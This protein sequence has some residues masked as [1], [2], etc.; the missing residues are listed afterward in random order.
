MDFENTEGV[1]SVDRD[2]LHVQFYLRPIYQA[3]ASEVEGR[4]IFKDV[5]YV[6]IEVPGDRYTVCDQKATEIH[7]RRWPE[8]WRAFQEGQKG[9]LLE[10]GD[11]PIAQWAALPRFRVLELKAMGIQSVMQLG[12]VSDADIGK[13]GPCARSE[14][15]LAQLSLMSPTDAEKA[16]AK[17]TAELEDRVRELEARLRNADAMPKKRE[18]A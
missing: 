18:A 15:D 8:L 1:S 13:L 10:E 3:R 16:A 6:R 14:R 12:K 9:V 11:V 5:P 17:R 7:Q 2:G 4:P